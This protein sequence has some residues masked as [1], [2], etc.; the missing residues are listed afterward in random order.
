MI[1]YALACD[2]GHS[3]ESW[4]RSS[5]DFDVQ[6]RRGLVACPHC[7]S[8]RVSKQIMAPAIRPSPDGEI[9]ARSVVMPDPKQAE[10]QQMM[11]AF[12][13]FVEQNA[14]N[15][16]GDFAEEARKIH[17]GETEERAIYGQA[18]PAEVRSLHEEGV[19]VAPLPI[20]PDEHH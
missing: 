20:L 5:D 4:F 3:F 18:T 7:G 8:P 10:F 19:E 12:R 16:G 9:A 2:A 15:V 17:Y 13:Q 14:E 6:A 11:R 1:R